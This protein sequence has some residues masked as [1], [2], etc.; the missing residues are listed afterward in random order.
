VSSNPTQS[1]DVHYVKSSTDQTGNQ[2]PRGN[3]KKDVIIIVGVR[4]IIINPRKMVIMRRRIIMLVREGKK[5][6]R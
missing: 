2:Q 5:G 1:T 4:I 6:R 3:K